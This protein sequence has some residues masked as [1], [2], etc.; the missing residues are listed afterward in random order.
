N[1]YLTIYLGES[2]YKGVKLRNFD[3]LLILERKQALMYRRV[4][5]NTLLGGFDAVDVKIL[6]QVT[7]RLDFRSLK[8]HFRGANQPNFLDFVRRSH[9][10]IDY[11]M[12]RDVS[13]DPQGIIDLPTMKRL[14]IGEGSPKCRVPRVSYFANN[15]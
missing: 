8:V 7:N 10:K 5:V 6:A 14:D 2:C 15:Q 9:D 13:P 11:V 1:K 3:S 12:I 4:L